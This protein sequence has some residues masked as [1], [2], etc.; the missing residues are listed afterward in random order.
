M[1]DR[2]H[3]S[4]ARPPGARRDA[5]ATQRSGKETHMLSLLRNEQVLYRHAIAL[6][7]PSGK[8]EMHGLRLDLL[9]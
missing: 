2:D 4:S 8:P 5:I 9:Q 3:L 7:M 6:R 1:S